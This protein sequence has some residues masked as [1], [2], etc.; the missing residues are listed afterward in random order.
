MAPFV[1][2]RPHLFEEK[3]KSK[4]RA[5]WFAMQGAA[6]SPSTP[7]VSTNLVMHLDAGNSSSYDG[8]SQTWT[9]LQ[10]NY[11]LIRGTTSGSDSTD[12]TFNGTAGNRS[13]NEYFSVD[14]G[15]YFTAANAYAGTIIRKMFRSDQ[16]VTFELWCYMASLATCG[17]YGSLTAGGQAGGFFYASYSA[18]GKSALSNAQ[19]A[20]AY[21]DFLS[22][23]AYSASAWMQYGFAGK[24]DGSTTCRFFKNGTDIYTGTYSSNHTSGDSGTTPTFFGATAVGHPP[25][26]S[27]IAILRIYDAVLTTTQVTQNYSANKARFGLS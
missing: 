3:D 15:D 5:N 17:F 9:D 16:A 2:R 12:P 22:T 18:D 7:I 14:G 1:D 4:L 6:G 27:R 21:S 20:P 10:G 24:G 8:S 19:S 23:A 11:N 25:S 26:G 13:S